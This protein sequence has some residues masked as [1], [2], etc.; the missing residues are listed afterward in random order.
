MLALRGIFISLRKHCLLEIQD[1]TTQLHSKP[2]LSPAIGFHM[3][4]Q[5]RPG[6]RLRLDLFLRHHMGSF[7]HEIGIYLS[8]SICYVSAFVELKIY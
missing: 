6:S 4:L 3:R 8:S 7:K 5:G 1:L 2:C